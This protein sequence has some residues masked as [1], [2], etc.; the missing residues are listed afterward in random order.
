M[1]KNTLYRKIKRNPVGTQRNPVVKTTTFIH[2]TCDD[3]DSPY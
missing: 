1:Y 2:K 3:L